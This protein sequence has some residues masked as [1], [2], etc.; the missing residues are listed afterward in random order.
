MHLLFPD[1]RLKQKLKDL[2]ER[3][4]SNVGQIEGTN[5]SNSL[6]YRRPL[7]FVEHGS[8]ASGYS[9]IHAHG[10]LLAMIQVEEVAPAEV[11]L[12]PKDLADLVKKPSS[13]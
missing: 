11:M 12:T 6:A 4:M 13:T 10:R 2:L 9:Q 7:F 8:Q 5:Q 1:K 3:K